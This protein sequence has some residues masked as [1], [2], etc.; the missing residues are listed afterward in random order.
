MLL[1]ILAVPIEMIEL[2]LEVSYRCGDLFKD[3]NARADDFGANPVARDRGDLV[4]TPVGRDR[5]G[6][7][8]S[9]ASWGFEVGSP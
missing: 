9:R 8:H 1:V 3:P 6:R 7:R 2:D 5:C 4:Q